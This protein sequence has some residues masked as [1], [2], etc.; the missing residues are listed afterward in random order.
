MWSDLRIRLAALFRRAETECDMAEEL[1]AHIERETEKL[2]KKGLPERE[3]R[4]KAIAAFGSIELV[5][6]RSRDA[7]GTRWIEDTWRDVRHAVGLLGRQKRLTAALVLT[8][9]LGIGANTAVIGAIDEILWRPLTMPDADRIVSVWSFDRTSSKYGQ[10]SL[11]DIRDL[12]RASSL[13]ALAGYWRRPV[14]A[15]FGTHSKTMSSEVVTPG[16]FRVLTAPFVAGRAFSVDEESASVPVAVIS[17][18]LWREGFGAAPETVGG[19]IVLDGH[20]VPIVGVASRQFHGDH[21]LNWYAAPDIWLPASALPSLAGA[22]W[23]GYLRD[24][25]I[26]VFVGLGRLRPGMSTAAADA[27]LNGIFAGVRPSTPAAV[28]QT[29]RVFPAS[30]S[31]FYPGY[32][33]AFAKNLSAF[34]IAALLILLLAAANVANLLVESTSRRQREIAI[35]T[36]LGAG[37]GRVVRQLFV[38]GL[39]LAVPG[40][41]ASLL[42]ASLLQRGLAAF[43][44][45]LGV[46][47]SL[48]LHITG[49]VITY[50]VAVSLL[51]AAGVSLVPA[52]RSARTGA[53]PL[54]KHRTAGGP[55]GRSWMSPSLTVLQ[56]GLS[57]VLLIGSLVIARGL[58][59][60]HKV[61]LGFDPSPTIILA[62][63]RFSATDGVTKPLP[64]GLLDHTT[65]LPANVTHVA[66]S[67]DEPFASLCCPVS[68]RDPASERDPVQAHTHFVSGG[69]F[70][71]LQIPLLSGRVFDERDAAG[72]QAVLVN[73]ALARRFWGADSALGRVITTGTNRLTVIGVVGDTQYNDA[74]DANVLRVYRPIGVDSD[75]ART[76]LGRTGRPPEL[77]LPAIAQGW[78]A[79]APD[80]PIAEATT[81]AALRARALEPMRLTGMLIGAFAL[82]AIAIA[83]VG[84]YSTIAW[85]V[86]QRAREIAV[87]IA[88]GGA[89]R[90]IGGQVMVRALALT[91]V[92]A[93]AGFTLAAALVPRLDGFTHGLAAQDAWVMT[94]GAVALAGVSILSAAMPIR[95]AMR[96]DPIVILKSE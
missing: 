70:D 30:E 20:R 76:V 46:E 4:R 12:E 1:R 34:G 13:Q 18:R 37:R 53:G 39:V 16:Y 72:N 58:W 59:V 6:E 56:I 3:A 75:K 35:R 94:M 38:E 83:G 21:N 96:I 25:A 49:R 77:M 48:N 57:A 93:A 84:L 28:S 17:E 7:R 60:A 23:E 71:T 63:D 47:L 22:R 27:E 41:V 87:R 29:L 95:R 82:I 86:E 15:T 81:G 2:L 44:S 66:L 26:P 62:I 14:R 52:I 61:P 91:F 69:F 31:K 40:F 11:P 10:L 43:P 88:I 68:V 9:A 36:A 80:V 64:P 24:R 19:S 79:I 89:P 33:A 90:R 92:G 5:K 78:N 65:W 42:V 50:C 51:V 32:R 74:W 45:A 85:F 55:H 67:S 54:L 8:M 73:N